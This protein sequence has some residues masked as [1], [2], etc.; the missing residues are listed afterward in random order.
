MCTGVDSQVDSQ[1][2]EFNAL[3]TLLKKKT[4]KNLTYVAYIVCRMLAILPNIDA[5]AKVASVTSYAEKS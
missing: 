2:K 5:K 4:K 3:P 1:D